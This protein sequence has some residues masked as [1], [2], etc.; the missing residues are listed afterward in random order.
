MAFP[1]CEKAILARC[2]AGCD[3]VYAAEF[4]RN[5]LTLS[6]SAR[7]ARTK[8]NLP[9]PYRLSSPILR[10]RAI[11]LAPIPCLTGI[12]QIA[13]GSFGTMLAGQSAWLP[14]DTQHIVLEAGGARLSFCGNCLMAIRELDR[15]YAGAP[16]E[17]PVARQIFRRVPESAVVKR[18][19]SHTA[20]VPNC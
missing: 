19:H 5:T 8:P 15:R 6:M 20:V 13:A 9:R 14:P 18:I 2:P 7:A 11:S 4:C 1:E 12:H 17:L 10:C 3:E 16:V